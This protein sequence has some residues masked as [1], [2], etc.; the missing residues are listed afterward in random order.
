MTPDIAP[1]I[2]QRLHDALHEVAESVTLDQLPRLWPDDTPLEPRGRRTR[3]LAAAVIVVALAVGVAVTVKA[4]TSATRSRS[5]EHRANITPTTSPPFVNE[6][7]LT[8]PRFYRDG[9]TALLPPPKGTRPRVT[10]EEAYAARSGYPWRQEPRFPHLVLADATI[11][12]YGTTHNDG[13]V[14][15]LIDH[16][17]AWVVTYTDVPV[18]SLRQGGGPARQVTRPRQTNTSTAPLDPS[19][20]SGETVLVFVDATTGES[21][22]AEGFPGS[23]STAPTISCP[24]RAPGTVPKQHIAGTDSTLV[25]GDPIELLTCRYHGLNQPEP[26]DTLAT[27][28]RLAPVSIVAALN[29]Q[30]LVP[31]DAIFSCPSDTGETI[32]LIFGYTDGSRLTV[33]IAFAGCRFANNGDRVVDTPATTLSQL[34]DVVGQ[35]QQHS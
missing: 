32:M 26:A 1:S 2:E 9:L 14:T 28:A 19:A 7:A 35:D 3:I 24:I 4:T 27:S 23:F 18:G 13:S 12:D 15:P 34:Q 5:R 20:R 16:R 31:K 25:P 21:I 29:A 8:N 22:D 33:S 6:G 17:L 30:P 10:A 11:F